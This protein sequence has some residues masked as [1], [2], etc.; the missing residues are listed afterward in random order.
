MLDNVKV[1]QKNSQVTLSFRIPFDLIQ[2]AEPAKSRSRNAG[3]VS[4]QRP[5]LPDG[6]FNP[7]SSGVIPPVVLAQP[8][9]Y[10]TEEARQAKIEGVVILQ[11]VVRKDGSTDRFVVKQGL[12][13]GLDESAIN[14]IKNRWR[15]EPG[16]F[17]GKPV[18]VQIMVEV[19]FRLYSRPQDKKQMPV[20]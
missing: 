13:H 14:T 18:D 2:K 15:F 12:G 7:I 9:P 10:Y 17:N 1:S 16:T 3:G 19:S 8:L 20:R 5:S 6:V 11:L 4:P